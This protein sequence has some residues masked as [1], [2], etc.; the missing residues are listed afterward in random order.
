[1]MP[2]VNQAPSCR[3]E[4]GPQWEFQYRGYGGGPHRCPQFPHLR[5]RASLDPASTAA[6]ATAEVAQPLGVYKMYE[7]RPKSKLALW[8]LAA[9]IQTIRYPN[10]LDEVKRTP[11]DALLGY[12][13]IPTISQI[14]AEPLRCL[15]RKRS[16]LLEEDN[17]G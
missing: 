6:W 17:I 10:L 3:G 12:Q 1:M 13:K 11:L 8:D 5:P 2:A 16:P 15:R 14:L 7:L 9:V 4:F